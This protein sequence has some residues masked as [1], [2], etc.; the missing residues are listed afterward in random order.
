MKKI[1]VV[2]VL[3]IALISVNVMSADA[4]YFPLAVGNVWEHDLMIQG[5]AGL[6]DMGDATWKIYGTQTIGAETFYACSLAAT[7]QYLAPIET[8]LVVLIQEQGNDIFLT[9]NPNSPTALQKIGQH[10][11]TGDETW[12][13]D[14][15]TVA[16]SAAGAYTV[17]AGSFNSCFAVKADNDTSAVYAPNVGPLRIK[18]T[19]SSFTIHFFL[20]KYTVTVPSDIRCLKDGCI[21]DAAKGLFTADNAAK[22][23]TFDLGDNQ[24]AALS[25]YRP[26]GKLVQKYEIGGIGTINVNDNNISAGQILLKLDVDGKV[27]TGKMSLDR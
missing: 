5:L 8:T 7:I 1:A 13:A 19:V 16:V 10:T 18:L 24:K 6:Q 11:Y 22:T 9:Q 2:T 23:I 27:Y 3:A 14:G 12:T 21:R 25:L 17:P 4:D 26:N 15:K 20:K